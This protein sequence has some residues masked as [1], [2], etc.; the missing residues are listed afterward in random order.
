M[1]WILQMDDP[2]NTCAFV[3]VAHNSFVIELG[4]ERVI[5][6]QNVSAGKMIKIEDF[7]IFRTIF[8]QD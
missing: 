1:R 8:D 2:R 5:D 3:N 6:G 4:F 7:Y